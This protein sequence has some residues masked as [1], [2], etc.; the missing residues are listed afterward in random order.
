MRRKRVLGIAALT[1]ATSIGGAFA[2]HNLYS[3]TATDA[4]HPAAHGSS[5]SLNPNGSELVVRAFTIAQGANCA[6]HS[7]TGTLQPRYQSLVGFRISGKIASRHVE[8][9]E[10][11]KKGQ[12]LFK[13][14]PDDA[15][16]QLRVAEADQVSADSLFKQTSAEALRLAQLRTSGSVSLSDYDLAIAGR[17]VAKARLDAA[18]RRLEL[19]KNQRTYCDLVADSDGLV[20]ALQAESGQVV[21]VGQP[22]LQIM[23]SDEM[24]VIVNLPEGLVSIVKGLEAH[25][26]FWSRPDVRLRAELRELSPVADPLSRTYDA[27]FRLLESAP[28]LAIGMTASILLDNHAEDGTSVPLASISSRDGSPIVW[29]IIE[30]GKVEPIAVEI[31]Q[32]RSDVA[33]VRGNLNPSDR[34]VSAGVQRIDENATVRVWES[35]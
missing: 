6:S 4:K 10:R 13:L 3:E 28:D 35:K 25:A 11:V 7:F 16:L 12:V 18:D 29:R 32:Y 9:G 33:I 21:N 24:E 1:V 27:R 19:A 30:N 31:V 20:T 2:F 15:D 23:H 34:I 22:V 26:T 8:L 14:N 5:L 17:D